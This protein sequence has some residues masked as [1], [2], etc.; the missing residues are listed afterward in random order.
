MSQVGRTLV[1]VFDERSCPTPWRNVTPIGPVLQPQFERENQARRTDAASNPGRSTETRLAPRAGSKAQ[2]VMPSFGHTPRQPTSAMRVR[3]RPTSRAPCFNDARVAFAFRL[4][5]CFLAHFPQ[6]TI[7]R[8]HFGSTVRRSHP[9]GSA[10]TRALVSIAIRPGK[11]ADDRN[12][13][14]AVTAARRSGAAQARM[15]RVA[16]VPMLDREQLRI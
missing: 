3:P 11:R 13:G 10:R 5:P 9:F 14:V 2:A 16:A 15:E 7:S 1:L 8:R 4:S 6:T 12:L